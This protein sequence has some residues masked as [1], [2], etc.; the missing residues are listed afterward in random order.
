MLETS[1]LRLEWMVAR[2]H[3]LSGSRPAVRIDESTTLACVGVAR[4][5]SPGKSWRWTIGRDLDVHEGED[6]ALLFSLRW[7]WFLGSFWLV[8][9][10]DGQP[11]GK[12]RRTRRHGVLFRRLGYGEPAAD[13][14]GSVAEIPSESATH[15]G[16]AVTL[17]VATSSAGQELGRLRCAGLSTWVT[18]SKELDSDPFAKMLLVAAALLWRR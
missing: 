16:A 8:L 11:I 15:N 14:A 13:A 5:P 18:F 6:E 2:T 4:A 17:A 9:D 12:I 10:A 1:S 7:S 3:P